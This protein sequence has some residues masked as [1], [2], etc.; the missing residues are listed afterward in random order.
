MELRGHTE[1]FSEKHETNLA[2]LPNQSSQPNSKISGHLENES[3]EMCAED[4]T[5]SHTLSYYTLQ[6][7]GFLKLPTGR[8]LS[9]YKNFDKPGA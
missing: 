1:N 7:S 2:A 9:D 4:C 8:T 6:N 5:T 3:T